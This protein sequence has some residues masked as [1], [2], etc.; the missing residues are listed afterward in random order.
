MEFGFGIFNKPVVT[1]YDSPEE[2]RETPEGVRSTISDEGLY[3]TACRVVAVG[4]KVGAPLDVP[5]G[6]CRIITFYGY[7][8][9]VRTED[10]DMC[11]AAKLRTILNRKVN[12]ISRTADILTA[13]DSTAPCLITLGRGC[14]V[15]RLPERKATDPDNGLPARVTGWARV[16]LSDGRPGYVRALSLEPVRFHQD[17][18]FYMDGKRSQMECESLARGVEPE[19]LVPDTLDVWYG[20][21]EDA[22]RFSVCQTAKLYLGT[23]YR[24][25]GKSSSGVDCSGLC[26]GV[27][28]Q[29]GVLIYRDAQLREGWPMRQISFEEKKPGDLIFYPGHVVMYL[30]GNKY[31]HSTGAATSGGVVINSFDPKDPRYREDLVGKHI[32]VGTI[33]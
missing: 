29:H 25:G 6:W 27:Y 4:G 19:E 17:A 1:I 3:G 9:Y 33:F 32:A 10:L 26:S 24:W 12:M 18:V 8:G 20:G 15:Y 2:T 11:N 7:K 28:M 21:L 31:I 5:A 22:F 30:G 13:P 14:V 16:A 23:Q